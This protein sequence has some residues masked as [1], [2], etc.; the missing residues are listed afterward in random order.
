MHTKQQQKVHVPSVFLRKDGTLCVFCISLR[1]VFTLV[2]IKIT[3]FENPLQVPTL[4]RIYFYIIS[5]GNLGW[6]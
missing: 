3:H 1:V 5:Q 6:V 2:P 4:Q